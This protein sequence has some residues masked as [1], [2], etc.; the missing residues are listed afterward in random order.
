MRIFVVLSLILSSLAFSSCDD[1]TTSETGPCAGVKCS[2]HGTCTVYGEDPGIALCQCEWGYHEDRYIY[3]VPDSEGCQDYHCDGHGTCFNQADD[4]TIFPRCT[5][6]EGYVR[7]GD[8]HCVLGDSPDPCEGVDCDGHGTC[9]VI[10]EGPGWPVCDCD[11]GYVAVE[12]TCV[13]EA[14]CGDGLVNVE[15]EECDDG[16]DLDDDGCTTACLFSCH[17]SDGCAQDDNECVSHECT[18]VENGMMCAPV[19]VEG[20]CDDGDDCTGPDVCTDGVCGG[21]GLPVWYRD[22]DNDSYG[23]PPAPSARPPNRAATSPTPPTAA[24]GSPTRIRSRRS[25]SRTPTSAEA[26]IWTCGTMTTTR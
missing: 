16:N 17:P 19:P 6:D 5:C 15:G 14:G 24:P 13:V 1:S 3:C 26:W 22:A 12:L 10:G 8:I 21:A 9:G 4:G 7:V 25:T 20:A 18:A 2:N 11:E 23:D